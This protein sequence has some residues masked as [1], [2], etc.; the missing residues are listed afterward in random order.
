MKCFFKL[1]YCS[2]AKVQ[3]NFSDEFYVT[4]VGGV[5]LT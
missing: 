2:L 4:S 1:V 5:T 3:F